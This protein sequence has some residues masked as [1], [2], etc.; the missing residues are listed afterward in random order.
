MFVLKSLVTKQIAK[1]IVL[2]ASLLVLSTSI[3]SAAPKN[4]WHEP[5]DHEHGPYTSNSKFGGAEATS[6]QENSL[7]HNMYKNHIVTT[8]AG[9]QGLF[10]YHAGSNPLDRRSQFHSFRLSYIDTLGGISS[11]Q[12]WMDTGN[13]LTRR[14]RHSDLTCPRPNILIVEPPPNTE[15]RFEAWYPQQGNKIQ[16]IIYIL[17]PTTYYT[18]DLSV[19]PST[20]LYTGG[21]GLNRVVGFTIIPDPPGVYC[22]TVHG[23]HGP[24]DN[25]HTMRKV[26]APTL[27][28]DLRNGFLSGQTPY[29]AICPNC[30]AFN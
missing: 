15:V 30:G 28:N 4:Q 7:K 18:G 11:W 13:P 21:K 27:A 19:D 9:G 1:L 10:Q 25:Q 12:G 8:E 26:I 6:R 20:W 17:D 14:C 2:L 24:C 3:G 16:F 29:R 5:T 22:T 23:E